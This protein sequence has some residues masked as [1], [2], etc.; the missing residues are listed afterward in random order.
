MFFTFLP[1]RSEVTVATP[2]NFRTNIKR[3]K[4]WGRIRVTTA[5]HYF[6]D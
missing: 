3:N 1:F 4:K 2:L 5:D 6:D